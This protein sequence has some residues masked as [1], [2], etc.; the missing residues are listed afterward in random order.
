MKSLLVTFVN[1]LLLV[2]VL[3]AFP[4]LVEGCL[5]PSHRFYL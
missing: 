4:R 1:E 2:Q 3:L 5:P